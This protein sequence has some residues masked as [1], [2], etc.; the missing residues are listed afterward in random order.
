MVNFSNKFS[1]QYLFEKLTKTWK[2]CRIFITLMCFRRPTAELDQKMLRT[3]VFVAV[4]AVIVHAE[5]RAEMYP[6]RRSSDTMEPRVRQVPSV[7]ERDPCHTDC[8]LG[9]C[10]NPCTSQRR[11]PDTME[12]RVRQ[13]PSVLK[14]DPCHTDCS[15]GWCFNPCTSQS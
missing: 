10:F 15:L 6:Q 3:I 4:L 12:S 13:V 1:R 14:R 7:S 2:L 5:E 11:W 9:W 8:S